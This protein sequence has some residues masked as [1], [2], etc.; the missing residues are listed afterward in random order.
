[1]RKLFDRNKASKPDGWV[2]ISWNEIAE[3]TYIVPLTRYGT[4]YLRTI[5]RI[6]RTNR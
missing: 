2:F 1:M 6:I 3:G 4:R 5:G